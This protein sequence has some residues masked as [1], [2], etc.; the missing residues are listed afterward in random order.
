MRSSW[1][2]SRVLSRGITGGPP[3]C[4]S[5]L[6]L[7]RRSS[8]AFSGSEGVLRGRPRFVGL[9]ICKS[10]MSGVQGALSELLG[11]RV[12]DKMRDEQIGD[13]PCRFSHSAAQC[14]NIC[15][16]HDTRKDERR[17]VQCLQMWSRE[18]RHS[19]N[20]DIPARD[21]TGMSGMLLDTKERTIESRMNSKIYSMLLK[22]NK[23]SSKTWR[24]ALSGIFTLLLLLLLLLHLLI[25]L[26]YPRCGGGRAIPSGENG[27]A[28]GVAIGVANG[29]VSALCTSEAAIS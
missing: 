16:I 17:D 2:S 20:A 21:R 28:P 14:D 13:L 22:M 3:I 5:M 10:A 12:R 4:T 24:L 29:V 7:R 19:A 15:E 8:A 18:Q 1:S 26:E 27:D 6:S 25:G 23:Y 11:R 9:K